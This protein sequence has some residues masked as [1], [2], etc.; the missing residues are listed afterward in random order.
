MFTLHWETS[1]CLF[2]QQK[3]TLPGGGAAVDDGIIPHFNV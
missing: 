3:A 2:P 1:F